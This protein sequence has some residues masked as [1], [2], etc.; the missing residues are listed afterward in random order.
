MNVCTVLRGAIKRRERQSSK[1]RAH[2]H[3]NA[4]ADD[5]RATRV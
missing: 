4:F 2:R 5:T 1:R 3:M